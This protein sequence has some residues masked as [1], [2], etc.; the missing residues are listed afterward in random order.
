MK[1]VGHMDSWISIQPPWSPRDREVVILI[2]IPTIYYMNHLS[3]VPQLLSPASM[4]VLVGPGVAGCVST[5]CSCLSISG[6]DKPSQGMVWQLRASIS[7]QIL[8]IIIS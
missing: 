7:T 4:F 8:I 2:L 3:G 5:E 6:L 1:P